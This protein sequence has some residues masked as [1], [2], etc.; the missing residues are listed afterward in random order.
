M[1]KRGS[2][3]KWLARQRKDPFVRAARQEGLRSRAAFKLREIQ[4]QYTVFCPGMS[5][6]ELGAAPGSWSAE[7]SQWISPQ[8]RHVAID[9]LAMQDFADTEHYQWDIESVDFI[10]WLQQEGAVFDAVISDMAPNMCGHK[11]T[12]Q[13]RASGLCEQ[14]LAIARQALVPNGILLMKAFHGLGFNELH[15]QAK[16]SFTRACS[17]KPEASQRSA[18]ECYILA[19]GFHDTKAD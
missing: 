1:A 8:G 2:S 18:H 17:I 19:K 10:E 15:A 16:K 12:D 4:K 6:L 9:R 5:V 3:K 14:V 11:K 13:L 7:I